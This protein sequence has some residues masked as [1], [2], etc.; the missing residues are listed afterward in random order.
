MPKGYPNNPETAKRTGP[1]PIYSAEFHPADL[2]ARMSQG[3]T[4]VEVWAA[5][6]IHE[7]TFYTWL[8]QHC[9]LK[10]AYEHGQTKWRAA[11]M[12]KG[13]EFMNGKAGARDA[14]KYW[15]RILSIK[16][17]A[18][19]KHDKSGVNIQL[20]QTN[21]SYEGKS[22]AELTELLQ[23]KLEKLNLAVP[24]LTVIDAEFLEK[25]DESK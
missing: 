9:E 11:W 23:S 6:D 17:G 2:V 25:K 5:W 13:A 4:N 16:G 3:E 22:E 10:D 19:Y 8:E 1:K 21:I 14:F 18:E 20:N 7:T 15:D 12:A 24:Q